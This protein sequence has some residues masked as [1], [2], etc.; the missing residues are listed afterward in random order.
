[1]VGVSRFAL[2][3]PLFKASVWGSL[4]GWVEWGEER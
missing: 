2:P 1:M 3:L 4:Q